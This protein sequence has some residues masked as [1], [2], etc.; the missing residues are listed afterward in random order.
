MNN[1]D[2]FGTNTIEKNI[3]KNETSKWEKALGEEEEDIGPLP[4][5]EPQSDEECDNMD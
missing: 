3:S 2:F 5:V 1:N 4:Y